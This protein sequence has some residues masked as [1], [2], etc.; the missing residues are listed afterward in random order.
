[1]PKATKKTRGVETNEDD[2]DNWTVPK[3]K[4]FLRSKYARLE[5]NRPQ[6]LERAKCYLRKEPE[7]PTTI[8]Q[9]A[10]LSS[11]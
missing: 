1:M 10:I 6:L 2:I 11:L 7:D 4:D 5:G 9:W 3:L 8:A